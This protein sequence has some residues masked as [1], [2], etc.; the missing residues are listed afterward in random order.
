MSVFRKALAIIPIAAGVMLGGMSLSGCA[1]EGYVDKQI[2]TVN[3]RINAVDAKA[4]DAIQRA[5]AANAAAQSAGQAAQAANSAAQAAAASAQQ[6]NQG[7]DSL[8]S[9]VNA[10]EAKKHP[11]G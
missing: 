10:L 11:R 2:A 4:T 7:V 1:T 3:D 5:D 8:T 6:A 9:R